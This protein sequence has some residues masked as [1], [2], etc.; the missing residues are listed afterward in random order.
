MRFF[1]SRRLH[2][3]ALKKHVS[4]FP[5][6]SLYHALPY[7]PAK[8]MASRPNSGLKHRHVITASAM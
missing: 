3:Y 4:Y 5:L 2:C 8:Q 6:G 1:A 7:S